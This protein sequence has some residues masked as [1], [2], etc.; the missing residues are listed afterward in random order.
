MTTN[1]TERVPDEELDQMILK[2]ER[3]GGMAP[4]MLSLMRELREVRRAKGEPVAWTDVEELREARNGGSGY[5]FS[6]GGDANKFADPNRQLMLYTAPPAPVVDA[7]AHADAGMIT[8][9][10][11][12][13]EREEHPM[14]RN[15]NDGIRN[16]C[17]S[18][19]YKDK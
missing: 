13:H 10:H 12:Q 7:D 19:A 4:K 6:I 15:C 14:C 2:L 8:E 17:S 5:L 18:C 3:D 16:G 11:Q 9:G 1:Q